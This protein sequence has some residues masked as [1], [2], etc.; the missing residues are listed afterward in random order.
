MD[1]IMLTSNVDHKRQVQSKKRQG[2]RKLFL[3]LDDISARLIAFSDKSQLEVCW[4]VPLVGADIS[5][6]IPGELTQGIKLDEEPHCFYVRETSATKDCTHY[7]S[8]PDDKTKKEWV[9]SLTRVARNGPRLPRF[10]I[11]NAGNDYEFH[12]RV[13]KARPHADDTHA[14]YMITCWCQVYSRLVARRLMKEWSIWHRFSE[15]DELYQALKKSLGPQI[16]GIELTKHKRDAFRGVMGKAL[17]HDFLE[18]RRVLLNSFVANLSAIRPAVE[19]FKQH[20]DPHLRAFFRIGPFAKRK[21]KE[22]DP[23]VYKMLLDTARTMP[24]AGQ[25]CPVQVQQGIPLLKQVETD[26]RDLVGPQPAKVTLK[27]VEPRR[28]HKLQKAAAILQPA[29]RLAVQSAVRSGSVTSERQLIQQQVNF[30]RP[31]QQCNGYIPAST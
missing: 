31:I 28:R 23:M 25:L 19:F 16:E 8:V 27:A 9:K 17:D 12:A 22:I 24:V 1:G 30:D 10:T 26:R 21:S 4:S 6:P 15:F 20:S 13:V 18:A 11:S 29:I 14:E 5:T 2:W 3:K 7:F